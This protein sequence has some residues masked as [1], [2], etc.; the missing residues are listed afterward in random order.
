[1]PLTKLKT[2]H[3]DS[4]SFRICHRILKVKT[5]P[6][7]DHRLQ[8]RRWISL[9]SLSLSLSLLLSICS[10]HLC[11]IGK[12]LLKIPAFATP[13]SL[14]IAETHPPNLTP[15]KPNLCTHF[16]C[17]IV[18]WNLCGTRFDFLDL[19]LMVEKHGRNWRG[20]LLQ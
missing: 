18:F 8:I 14:W 2:L 4:T 7:T 12:S 11:H 9:C 6:I 3:S 5:P 13:C 16:S 15:K 20:G 19:D 17:P 1:M 10:Q